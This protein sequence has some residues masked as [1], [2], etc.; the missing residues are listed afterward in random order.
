[1][2]H[3]A[4]HCRSSNIYLFRPVLDHTG[5]DVVEEGVDGDVPAEGILERS[6]EGLGSERTCRGSVNAW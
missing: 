1:M 5:V 6:P 2:A 4:H 3:H